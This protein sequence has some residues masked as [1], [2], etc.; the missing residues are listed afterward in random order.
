MTLPRFSL[1]LL[2]LAVAVLCAWLAWERSVV[3][4]R[5]ALRARLESQGKVFEIATGSRS[6]YMDGPD[7]RRTPAEVRWPRR[8]FG[9]QAV[10]AVHSDVPWNKDDVI[11]IR[12]VFSEA[13]AWRSPSWALRAV[14]TQ[15]LPPASPAR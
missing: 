15:A 10:L 1:R 12:R 11:E 7:R 6:I 4:E 9:D 14:G 2:L 3:M 5:R 8:L 13:I